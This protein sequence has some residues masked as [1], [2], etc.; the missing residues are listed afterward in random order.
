MGRWSDEFQKQKGQFEREE[1][2]TRN[3]L[4][5]IAYW[6]QE[7]GEEQ[8][9]RTWAPLV[10]KVLR[11]APPVT[12]SLFQRVLRAEPAVSTELSEAFRRNVTDKVFDTEPN[13]PPV[14]ED[15]RAEVLDFMRGAAA[16]LDL[17]KAGATVPRFKKS[18][19]TAKGIVLVFRAPGFL[20]KRKPKK[21]GFGAGTLL[22]LFLVATRKKR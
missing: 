15:V 4:Q 17:T 2:Q 6:A 1:M 21:S 14:T 5:L 22:L 9:V 20:A 19:L 7:L 3:A 8:S 13:R 10:A 16:R 12:R 18:E 11:D